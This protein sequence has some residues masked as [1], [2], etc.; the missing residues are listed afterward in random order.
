MISYYIILYIIILCH[1]FLYYS[2]LYYII[3]YYI[4]SYYIIL[5]HI[6]IYY[7]I[8]YYIIL[9]YILLYHII[10]YYIILYY[11]MLYYIILYYTILYY[12]ISYYIILYYIILYFIILYH[13]ILYYICMCVW[14]QC[15]R[16]ISS[17]AET[18][19]QQTRSPQGCITSVRFTCFSQ[20]HEAWK[21]QE[22]G[23][24]KG[25]NL[26]IGIYFQWS[27]ILWDNTRCDK[28]K[29]EGTRL[30][31]SLVVFVSNFKAV[32]CVESVVLNM[33]ELNKCIPWLHCI[34]AQ[35]PRPR[36]YEAEHGLGCRVLWY[37]S[38]FQ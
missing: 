3:L 21:S 20:I 15:C 34:S 1:I 22:K 14:V 24:E 23:P 17:V 13:I 25:S 27:M 5:Y 31:E 32:F 7:S 10:L 12:I 28:R 19:A 16:S 11:I 33:N 2:I 8:L 30:R 4:I 38:K 37:F 35:R 29:Q 9:Y 36:A 26:Y 6:I 18:Q